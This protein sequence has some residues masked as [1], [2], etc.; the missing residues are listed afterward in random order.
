MSFHFFSV[1]IHIRIVKRDMN[2]TD[3][4]DRALNTV[5]DRLSSTEKQL[6]D[7]I[8]SLQA[9]LALPTLASPL[10]SST[11]EDKNQVAIAPATTTLPQA[12]QVEDM[13]PSPIS[14]SRTDPRDKLMDSENKSPQQKT[15]EGSGIEDPTPEES[16]LSPQP[17]R[18]PSWYEKLNQAKDEWL[19]NHE[20]T[21]SEQESLK[22][23]GIGT[24]VGIILLS[25]Y[26]FFSE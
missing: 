20:Y 6:S 25:S 4:L 19:E 22:A 9:P 11:L 7:L 16:K 8:I 10:P 17:Q 13:M 15:E 21:S 5:V 1:S 12:T 14:G 24:V 23:I 26:H 2:N 18:S 3:I